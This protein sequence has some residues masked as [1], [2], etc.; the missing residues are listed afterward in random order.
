MINKDTHWTVTVTSAVK[1]NRAGTPE[2]SE[3]S[4]GKAVWSS[5]GISEA[6]RQEQLRE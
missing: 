2:G 6:P 5:S 1:K 3:G 4:L